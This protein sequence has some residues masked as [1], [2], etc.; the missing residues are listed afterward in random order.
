MNPNKG[1]TH[2]FKYQLPKPTVKE[3][4]AIVIKRIIARRG[5]NPPT[6]TT[7][8]K[9]PIKLTNT[10]TKFRAPY[11]LYTN[12]T[13]FGRDARRDGN[14]VK[15]GDVACSSLPPASFFRSLAFLRMANTPLNNPNAMN[16]SIIKG[17]NAPLV[18]KDTK[19]ATKPPPT[20]PAIA[21]TMTRTIR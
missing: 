1:T 12:I 7:A 14:A 6:S 21:Y 3:Y 8:D 5:G 18:K 19:T 13:H 16:E 11:A 4:E 10:I 15:D 9:R 2:R 17:A 20:E